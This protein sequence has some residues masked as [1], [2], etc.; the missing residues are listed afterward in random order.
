MCVCVELDALNWLKSLNFHNVVEG[1]FDKK[2]GLPPS[3]DMIVVQNV[4]PDLQA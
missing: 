1:F 2:F 3:H 4:R